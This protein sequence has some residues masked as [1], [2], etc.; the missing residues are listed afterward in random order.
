MAQQAL[1]DGI[2]SKLTAVTSSGTV[3]DDVGGRIYEGQ[4][5]HDAA[6]PL[7]VFNLITDITDQHFGKDNI[8]TTVQFDIYGDRQLGSKAVRTTSDRL[9]T[10]LHGQSL[11][12]SGFSQIIPQC[13]ERGTLQ[14]EEDAYRMMAEFQIRGS[15]N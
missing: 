2:Y 7:L 15:R 9:F 5:P 11:T 6:L 10:L 1:V 3:Y 12:V 14:V 4:G 8:D 13:I